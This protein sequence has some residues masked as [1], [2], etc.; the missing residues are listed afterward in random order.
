MSPEV[1]SYETDSDEER[2]MGSDDEGKRPRKVIRTHP[3]TWRSEE[4]TNVLQSLDRK[5]MRKKSEKARAMVLPRQEGDPIDDN[6]PEGMP[7]WA[8]KKM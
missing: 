5:I 7:S 3:F 2:A 6:P 1:S 4:F 8:I